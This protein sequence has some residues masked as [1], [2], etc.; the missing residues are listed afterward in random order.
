M[1]LDPAFE[2]RIAFTNQPAGAS[3]QTGAHRLGERN[4][5]ETHVECAGGNG[6]VLLCDGARRN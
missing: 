5:G 1:F 4:L 2:T 3:E 6:G